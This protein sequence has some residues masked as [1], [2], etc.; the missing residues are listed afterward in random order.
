MLDL[1][2]SP[3]FA[4]AEELREQAKLSGVRVRRRDAGCVAGS[5]PGPRGRFASSRKLDPCAQ[6]VVPGGGLVRK[7]SDI[8]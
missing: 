8:G 2:L 4:G 6:D 5:E 3:D 7:S 1:V